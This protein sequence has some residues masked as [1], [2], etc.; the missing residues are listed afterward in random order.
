MY[1]KIFSIHVEQD[2]KCKQRKEACGDEVAREFN[3]S[4]ISTKAGFSRIMIHDG[5]YKGNNGI[6]DFRSGIKA[7]SSYTVSTENKAGSSRL[8]RTTNQHSMSWN[9]QIIERLTEKGKLS[10]GQAVQMRTDMEEGR[11]VRGYSH[12]GMENGVFLQSYGVVL[13]QNDN[14]LPQAM[15]GYCSSVHPQIMAEAGK[16]GVRGTKQLEGLDRECQKTAPQTFVSKKSPVKYSEIAS[17][18]SSSHAPYASTS[19]SVTSE[20]KPKTTSIKSSDS[21]REV[22]VCYHVP[23]S[24]ERIRDFI[25]YLVEKKK[26]SRT[27][28]AENTKVTRAVITSVKDDPNYSPTKYS[29]SDLWKSLQKKYP[30]EFNKWASRQ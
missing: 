30:Q 18:A 25:K 10:P 4:L 22:G 16:P 14:Q 11:F 19:Y 1:R 17:I 20:Q 26:F 6:D 28:I 21:K 12:I 2:Q 3:D 8:N 5:K 29:L 9:G 15:I 24:K 13:P 23:Y 7:G 27:S